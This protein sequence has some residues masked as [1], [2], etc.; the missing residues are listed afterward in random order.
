MELL[1]K[2]SACVGSPIPKTKFVMKRNVWSISSTPAAFVIRI[3]NP[4]H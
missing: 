2:N 3:C 1:K 4:K